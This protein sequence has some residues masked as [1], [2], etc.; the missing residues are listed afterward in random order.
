MP[1]QWLD[2]QT[3]KVVDKEPAEGVQLVSPNVEPG[4]EH[5]EWVDAA[6]TAAKAEKAKAK[7]A[8]EAAAA[9]EKAAAAKAAAAAAAAPAS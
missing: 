9:K 2:T 5:Q 8:A 1:G 6:K 7:A 3:G 4:P